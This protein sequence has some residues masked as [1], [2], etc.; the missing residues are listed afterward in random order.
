[1]LGVLVLIFVNYVKGSQ[2]GKN[3]LGRLRPVNPVGLGTGGSLRA[4][5]FS[6]ISRENAVFFDLG[7]FRTGCSDEAAS[8]DC[9]RCEGSARGREDNQVAHEGA[10]P[11]GDGR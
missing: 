4:R 8:S 6:E 5:Q 3:E 7:I 9:R 1:M 11:G 2:R 10:E